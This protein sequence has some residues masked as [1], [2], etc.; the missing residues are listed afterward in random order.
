MVRGCNEYK[1]CEALLA[2][3]VFDTDRPALDSMKNLRRALFQNAI[4]ANPKIG[5]EMPMPNSGDLVLEK[6]DS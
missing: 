5:F 6:G 2:E 3:L 1:N 4:S